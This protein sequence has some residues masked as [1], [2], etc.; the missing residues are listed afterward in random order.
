MGL[1]GEIAHK[2]YDISTCWGGKRVVWQGSS[3]TIKTEKRNTEGSF[4]K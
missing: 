2:Y 3:W 4:K 1:S